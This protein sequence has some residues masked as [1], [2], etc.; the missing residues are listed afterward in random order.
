MF[1]GPGQRALTRIPSFACTIASSLDKAKTAPF[2]AVSTVNTASIMG[3]TSDLRS[4]GSDDGDHTG[5]I[6]DAPSLS[7]PLHT[8]DSIFTTPPN[9]LHINSMR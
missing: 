7:V 1:K 9:P 3:T 6:D 4:C 2:D 5:S 8:L